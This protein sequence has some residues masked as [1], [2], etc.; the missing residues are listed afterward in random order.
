SEAQSKHA[1]ARAFSRCLQQHLEKS[2]LL[3]EQ[4]PTLLQDLGTTLE[5]LHTLLP[6]GRVAV[7][8]KEAT[9]LLSAQALKH[10]RQSG[11][12]CSDLASARDQQGR[13]L[14]RLRNSLRT[15]EQQRT[16]LAAE[17]QRLLQH[18][19][20]E[21]QQMTQIGRQLMLQNAGNRTIMTELL[22]MALAR[23]QAQWQALSARAH[24]ELART[25]EALLRQRDQG[26]RM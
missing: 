15:M 4:H 21:Q 26:S 23:S 17:Q 9:F 19:Q 25:Q 5:Q 13:E 18:W 11:H 1:Q 8:E 6:A 7:S 24:F 2:R 14:T 3:R 22:Q 20:K 16:F 12:A 10:C